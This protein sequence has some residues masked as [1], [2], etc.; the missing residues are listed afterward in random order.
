MIPKIVHTCWF[1]GGQMKDIH[2]SCLQSQANILNDFEHV[3]WSENNIDLEK[4]PA[5][6]MAVN[7][8][9]WAHVSDYIRLLVLKKYGG[10]YLDCDVMIKRNFDDIINREMFIGYMWDCD[11][12][13]A[14][15]G[16]RPQHKIISDLLQIYDSADFKF[17]FSMAN[18][19]I[20]TRYFCDHVSNFQLNGRADDLL[21]VSV[22]DKYSFEHPKIFADSGYS[23]HY[24]DASWKGEAKLKRLAKE[25]IIKIIGLP[26]YRKYVCFKSFHVSPFKNEYMKY[27]R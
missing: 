18:N 25:K 17:D 1:G 24:F 15:I 22:L 20:F 7:N 16:A 26:L 23:V 6:E 19:F 3:Q 11:L 21:D 8:K 10:I 4:Y 12:G 5:I 2:K 9:K 27:N 13:T 14:V